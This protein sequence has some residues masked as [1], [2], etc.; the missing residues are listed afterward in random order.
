MIIE[1]PRAFADALCTHL[2]FLCRGR[3]VDQRP[4]WMADRHFV[5][6]VTRADMEIYV[7]QIE[8]QMI[9]CDGGGSV[10]D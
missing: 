2:P 4:G 8:R 7:Q 10:V 3:V 1:V 5:G 6:F 9:V